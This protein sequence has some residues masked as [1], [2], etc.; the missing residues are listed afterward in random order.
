MKLDIAHLLG[1]RGGLPVML[2]IGPVQRHRAFLASLARPARHGW[3]AI[4]LLGLEEVDL[5]LLPDLVQ[6]LQR[7]VAFFGGNLLLQAGQ[8]FLHRLAGDLQQCGEARGMR[9]LALL[10][11]GRQQGQQMGD[12]GQPLAGLEVF[13]E[14]VTELVF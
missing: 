11:T 12:I 14:G 1:E 8:G 7:V 10:Q 6:G 2:E 13:V 5:L 4:L 3:A 9:A